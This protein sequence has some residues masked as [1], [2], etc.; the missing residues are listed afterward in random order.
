MLPSLESNAGPIPGE[1]LEWLTSLPASASDAE[2]RAAYDRDGLV[3]VKGVIPPEMVWEMRR[4]CVACVH[5][6]I[7][8]FDYFAFSGVLKPGTDPTEG[9]FCGGDP[10]LFDGP[11]VKTGNNEAN[12]SLFLSKTIEAHREPWVQEFSRNQCEYLND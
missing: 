11:G 6:D 7:R 10:E 4:K 2:L 5:A 3:H 12:D 1:Q 8:Y 9:I